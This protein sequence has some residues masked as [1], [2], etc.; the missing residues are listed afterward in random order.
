MNGFAQAT[1]GAALKQPRPKVDA[2]L[3]APT[4]AGMTTPLSGKSG[5]GKFAKLRNVG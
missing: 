1:G 4:G 3:N 5:A 2:P